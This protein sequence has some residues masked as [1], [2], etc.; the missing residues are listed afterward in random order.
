MLV[1]GELMPAPGELIASLRDPVGPRDEHLATARRAQLVGAVAVDDLTI[2]L[3]VHAEP[4]ADFGY[5]RPLIAVGDLELL[6]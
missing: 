2:A 1:D 3:Q 4:A 5:D 6:A